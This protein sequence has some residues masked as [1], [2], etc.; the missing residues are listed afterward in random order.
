MSKLCVI[1]GDQLSRDISSLREIDKEQDT[2]LMAEVIEE[3][4]YVHHH[5]HKL[6]LIFSAMRYFAR[7]LSSLGYHVIYTRLNEKDN[8]GS[9]SGEIKRHFNHDH[10]I[11]TEPGEYRLK[12]EI[13]QISLPI[14][15]LEDD[16][17]ICSHQKFQKW[18]EGKKELTM[19]FFY[20]EMR[21]ETNLLMSE[22]KPVQ[23]RWNFDK[24]NRKSLKKNI[25]IPSPK[26]FSPDHI[27]LEVI[28]MVEK[29]FPHN[30]GNPNTF[31][32]AVTSKE[33]TEVLEFF[34]HRQ[35]VFFGDYQDA[36]KS[37]EP[38]LF[39]SIL[40]AYI[41]IG[42]LDPL[43][44]CQ[45]VEKEFYEK[46][47]P[48]NCA[49][50][51]IRQI[52]GWREFIRGIYWLSGEKYTELNDLKANHTLPS[53]YWSGQ[54]KMN[55]LKQVIN[56][57]IKYGYSHHIQR[58]MVTGNYALLAGLDPFQVHEWYLAVYIDAFEWVEAPNT[59]G[60]ALHADGGIVG[61]KPYIASGAYINRMSDFCKSCVYDVKKKT[62]K[63]AC[64]FNYLYWD[65][66]IRHEKKFSTNQRMRI[67]YTN[68]N[69]LS[70]EQKKEIQQN[71]QKH[72]QEI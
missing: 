40:S 42:L 63:D 23:G 71:A 44:V 26:K 67:A 64:P 39:H 15:I 13:S 29:K 62:G 37:D 25:D 2:I 20:R 66:L 21:K 19:E 45:R 1:L 43:K 4:S 49:E 57:T 56:M 58:L 38:Y 46:R 18:A 41:N 48:I 65:F 60:M 70:N 34:C 27:T 8:S 51:F 9:I 52:I 7:E 24:E 50:G 22:G 31:N 17:F 68:L 28:D 47:I 54:T 16:R 6:V 5:T 32:Y 53:F 3:A 69:R 10:I 11:L 35:L 30:M 72:L 55:C 36:M 14:T 33:A 12:K 61:T 59:V